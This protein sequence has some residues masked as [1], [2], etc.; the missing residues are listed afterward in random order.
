VIVNL[1]LLRVEP[2]EFVAQAQSA[3]DDVVLCRF[4]QPLTQAEVQELVAE[5]S[6]API[7]PDK[8]DVR[9][10][11]HT[12]SVRDSTAL[13][14]DGLS[15]HTDGAFLAQPPRRFVLS[16]THTDSGGGGM[17]L[18]VPVEFVLDCAPDWAL[19]GLERATFRFLKSYDG[20]LTESYVGPVLSRDACGIPRIRWRADHLCRPCVVDAA[21]T[22]ATDAAA[23]LH[24]LLEGCAPFRY[25]LRSN[26]LAVVPNERVV[27]G[28]TALSLAS[29]RELLRAWIF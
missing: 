3:P 11:T 17:S 20:D 26:E 5:L 12:P 27:H 18:F 25:T 14:L 15:L 21:D 28:R 29:S 24:E 7:A 4:D 10:I 1:E 16:C 9:V 13:S 8:V 6:S 2:G 22:R 19:A 23:W